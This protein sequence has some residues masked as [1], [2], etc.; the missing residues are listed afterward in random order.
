M[1]KSRGNLAFLRINSIY[2]SGFSVLLLLNVPSS[3]CVLLLA[4][5]FTCKMIQV[6]PVLTFILHN[7]QRKRA[8]ETQ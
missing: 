7:S 3:L 6:F 1:I 2:G 8:L 4:V 5:F